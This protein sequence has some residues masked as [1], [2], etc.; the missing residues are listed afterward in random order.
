MDWPEG[1]WVYNEIEGHGFLAAAD[2]LSDVLD[3][4]IAAVEQ[5]IRQGDGLSRSLHDHAPAERGSKQAAFVIFLALG[6]GVGFVAVLLRFH[7]GRR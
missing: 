6:L 5:S 2:P 3:D 7:H 4:R 1:I